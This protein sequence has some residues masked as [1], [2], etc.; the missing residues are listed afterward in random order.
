MH[1]PYR[2]IRNAPFML[3]RYDGGTTLNIS[4]DGGALA[5][6]TNTPVET[7]GG[8]SV[9]VNELTVSEM[10]ADH[11]FLIGTN[12][13]ALD[14]FPLIPEPCID[15]GVAQAGGSNTI[16]LR[17]GAPAVG[18]SGLIIEIVRGTGKDQ[19]FRLIT[20]YDT[21]TKVATVRPNWST[22][23][24]NT[25]VYIVT[26]LPKINMMQI[27]GIAFPAQAMSEFWF[28]AYDTGTF[29]AGCTTSVL[30]TDMTGRGTNN[31]VGAAIINLGGN[32]D[33]IMRAITGYNTGSGQ[34]TVDPPY[35]SAPSN[36]DR[37]AVFGTTG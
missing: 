36:G 23:P 3:R 25:S 7:P 6:A 2:V 13:V 37:F 4:K 16:T 27:D 17:A 33:G 26:A 31:L 18:L 5:L 10:T 24:D 12:N 21:G 14:T 11:L 34:I 9:Y 35:A 22:N 30:N 1:G 8:S 32:N 15:S 19:Q 20:D 29:A 28:Y